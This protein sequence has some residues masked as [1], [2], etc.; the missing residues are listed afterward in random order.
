[1][2]LLVRLSP[3]LVLAGLIV[4]SGP[5]AAEETDAAENSSVVSP[6]SADERNPGIKSGSTALL[7]SFLGTAVP[8]VAA[9][10]IGMT[11]TRSWQ[12]S[13]WLEV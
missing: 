13:C 10:C 9:A 4:V 7:W 8:V 12:G 6:G 11:A 3:F 5:A 1:M 2:N